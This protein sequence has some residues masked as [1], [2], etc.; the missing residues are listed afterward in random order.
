MEA[1]GKNPFKG[2]NQCSI[3]DAVKGGDKGKIVGERCGCGTNGLKVREDKRVCVGGL[4][5][6]KRVCVSGLWENRRVCV[7]G[8]WEDRGCVWLDCGRTEG[9]CGWI[10]GG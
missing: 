2:D 8:L 7:A 4:W 9:V 3:H 5:E 1:A 6:V 10:V